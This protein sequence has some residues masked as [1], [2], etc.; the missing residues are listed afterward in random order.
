[1]G[2]A[3]SA[4]AQLVADGTTNSVDGISLGLIGDVTVGTNGSLTL[5]V[6]TNGGMLANSENIIISASITAQSNYVVVA[7]PGSSWTST[8]ECHA[9]DTGAFSGLEILDGGRVTNS[10]GYIGYNSSAQ[11]N[12][13]L[14][15]DAGS[16]WNAGALL[17]GNSGAGN[18]LIISNGATV[19]S[20]NG[21]LGE[22]NSSSNN[23]AIVTGA[24]SVWS[25]TATAVSI[26]NS[27]PG[28]QLVVSNG[29][30][31]ASGLVHLGLSSGGNVAMVTGAGSVWRNPFLDVGRYPAN[32]NQLIIEKGGKVFCSGTCN[33]GIYGFSNLVMVTD[34]GSL[35]TNNQFYIGD[36]SYANQLIV[37]NGAVAVTPATIFVA[38]SGQNQITVTG[39]GSL[40][41]N[42]FDFDLGFGAGPCL[43]LV[44]N[45]GILADNNGIIGGQNSTGSNN[46][47]LVT[48]ANSVWTNASEIHIG[49]SG[50]HNLL[51]ISNGAH[52]AALNG[53]V[54]NS[55]GS[56]E[57]LLIVTG[58]G[59]LLTNRSIF[60][61]GNTGS[62]NQVI[63][64]GGGRVA[65]VNGYVGYHSGNN[66]LMISDPGSSLNIQ[67]AFVCGNAGTF[68]QLTISNGGVLAAGNSTLGG[69]TGTVAVVTGAGSLWQ[70]SALNVGTSGNGAQ[71]IVSNSGSIVV[72]GTL[73]IGGD[74]VFNPIT[75]DNVIIAGGSVTLAI[76]TNLTTA[77]LPNTGA[78][79]LTIN[80][81]TFKG[82]LANP[83]GVT[84]N[85][86]LMQVG[87]TTG[88]GGL[89]IGNGSTA[90]TFQMLGSGT[91]S[92]TK[93]VVTN[94]GFLFGSGRI[95]ST[96]TVSAGGTLSPGSNSLTGSILVTG[97]LVLASNSACIMK[98]NPGLGAWDQLSQMT[99]VTYGGALQLTNVSGTLASGS[100]FR[101]FSA[102]SYSNA[103]ANILPSAPGPGL[104]WDTNELN[105]DGVLRV[106]SISTPPPVVGTPSAVGGK[107]LF[108]ASGIPYDAC[109]LYSSTDPTLPL[110]SWTP[111]A[112]NFFGSDGT[113]TFTNAIFPN[114]P[115]Q[116]F[117]LQVN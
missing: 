13:V 30:L 11:S 10:F 82:N 60:A 39:P 53:Y 88:G 12:T 9:G 99:N 52:V 62:F 66:S 87:G 108:S 45:G 106:Y 56:S 114:E 107:L 116:Y 79:A 71:L 36:S 85:G 69:S 104:R 22:N 50:S 90:A 46:Q 94:N 55:S 20:T 61:C 93:L 95:N 63:I 77:D 101:L 32:N 76:G 28:N 33:L 19:L 73:A 3:A 86:G 21:T 49:D 1:M 51:V 112:T 38:T 41:T 110:S 6:V 44:T 89:T 27:G 109:Y 74:F 5:L 14:V 15:S 105:V 65:A 16:V 40:L 42:I 78:G 24:G 117:S 97:A 7:G 8:G 115:Q 58:P 96:V 92:L 18:Q 68:N 25:N 83:G 47:A 81:G 26:G 75:N 57:N 103:F 2:F 98:L 59:S 64:S 34:P 54:G 29:G 111:I 70:T 37:S 23:L 35:L 113:I 4:Q 80:S 84:F 100:S 102:S 43:L 17:I 91:H 67:S 48:G 72:A 31:F